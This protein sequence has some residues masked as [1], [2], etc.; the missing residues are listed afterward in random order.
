[1][2]QPDGTDS[3]RGDEDALLAQ[4]IA[5]SDLSVS[6]KIDGKLDDGLL[7]RFIHTIFQIWFSA[8]DFKQGLNS[9][10]IPGGLIAVKGISGKAHD[11]TGPGDI[12]QFGGKIE[13]SG[14]VPDDALVKTFHR[15]L[16]GHGARLMVGSRFHQNGVPL[17]FQG[18]TVRLSRN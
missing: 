9:T 15:E 5:G 4:F 8:T 14:L 17:A 16:R 1:M 18:A 7:G 6:W 13:K 11:T 3:R 12:A 2:A 10:G